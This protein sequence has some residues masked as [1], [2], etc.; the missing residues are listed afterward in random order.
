[1]N[2][3]TLVVPAAGAG[4]RLG[5]TLP[6]LL[7][8]VGGI[9]M[10][11]R[12]QALYHGVVDAVILVVSPAAEAIVQ[13]HIAAWPEPVTCVVQAE[14]TGMLDAIGLG[15]GALAARPQEAWITWCDQVGVHPATI[16]RLARE[17]AGHAG[18]ACIFPT[19]TRNEPYIHFEADAT[20]RLVAVRQRREGDVMPGRGESDMGLF[21]LSA[22]AC[23][24]LPDYARTAGRG[25]LTGERNFL[26]MI[27]WLAARGAEVV[28]FPVV[29]EMEAVGVNTPGE[30]ALVERYLAG[31]EEAR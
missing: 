11:D 27:P 5:H 20:G 23:R 2:E 4:S 25:S 13:A 3:R 14:P 8:P 7:V 31:R 6:K 19:V 1:M 29:D 30:L 28:T 17:R 10:I 15:I 26:P 9:A 16:A 21:S 18:A 22:S 12:L 24:A